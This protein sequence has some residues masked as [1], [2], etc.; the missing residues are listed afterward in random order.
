M[1]GNQAVGGAEVYSGNGQPWDQ[2]F[3][4]VSRTTDGGRTWQSVTL[5]GDWGGTRPIMTFADANHGYLLLAFLRGGGPGAVF[6]TQDGGASWRRVGGPD[7]L[8]SVFGVTT[9]GTLWAG[10][11]GDAGPVGRPILD[12]SRDGGSTWSD[13]RLPGLV[14]DIYVN[15]ILV[16]PPVVVGQDGMVAVVAGSSSVPPAIRLFR[17]TDGGRTWVA[18]AAISENEYSS[19]AAAMKASPIQ[20]SIDGS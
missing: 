18:A 16:A 2:L 5:P 12:V 19:V 17:T 9:D 8:G 14:G 20:G 11:Q 10:N 1:D 6:A 7:S 13:A 15:D 4:K 3:V